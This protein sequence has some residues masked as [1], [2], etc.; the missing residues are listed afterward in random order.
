MRER[1]THYFGDDCPGGH[2]DDPL[3]PK[4]LNKTDEVFCNKCGFA[5][6]RKQHYQSSCRYEAIPLET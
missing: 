6:P 4:E 2:M 3:A 1:I 5:G